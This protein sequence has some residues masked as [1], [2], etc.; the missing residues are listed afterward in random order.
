MSRNI[1]TLVPGTLTP[2]MRQCE[3]WHPWWGARA[4]DRPGLPD[5]HAKLIS[6]D[7]LI[8]FQQRQFPVTGVAIR[9]LTAGYVPSR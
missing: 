2:L 4:G 6:C 5:T 1:N 7:S 8:D 9:N 3:V